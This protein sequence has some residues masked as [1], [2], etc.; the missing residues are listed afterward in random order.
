M[1]RER[2]SAGRKKARGSGRN[3]RKRSGKSQ[4]RQRGMRDRMAAGEALERIREQ[5]GRDRGQARGQA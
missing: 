5:E 4:E 3:A 1:G 2:V